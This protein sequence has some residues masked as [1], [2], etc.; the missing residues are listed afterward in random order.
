MEIVTK[1]ERGWAGHF[2][3]ADRCK[4]RRNTLL[5]YKDI[6]IVIS[7]VG[8]FYVTEEA[9]EPTTIGYNRHFETM[10]FYADYQDV[11]Y[12]DAD[13]SKEVYFDFDWQTAESDADDV[14]NKKHDVIVAE[15]SAKLLSGE[16]CQYSTGAE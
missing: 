15:I 9:K 10:A 14:H 7:S 5:E 2:I 6:K 16:I 8:L 13:V 1:T 12:Y 11:R 4:F 3:C